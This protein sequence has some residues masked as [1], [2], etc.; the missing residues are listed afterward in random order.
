MFYLFKAV[1][2]AVGGE[3]II[4]KKEIKTMNDRIKFILWVAVISIAALAIVSRVA[5]LRK[6]VTGSEA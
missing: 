5:V 2:A 3:Q 1:G 4:K 6:V